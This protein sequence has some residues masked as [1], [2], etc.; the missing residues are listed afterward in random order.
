MSG[1]GWKERII[2]LR[3]PARCLLCGRVVPAGEIFC[4]DCVKEI[5]EKP[6][7]RRIALPGAGAEGFFVYS[8]MSYEGGFR[9]SIH[10][11]KFRGQKGLADPMGR[12]LA[13]S[14]RDKDLS[15]DAVTW[16]PMT[17]KK[18]RER[19]Y[20]QSELLARAAAKELGIPCLP[21]LKKVRENKTQH[22]LSGRQRQL[23]VKNAYRAENGAEGKALLLI[24]DIVTTGATIGECAKMLYAAGANKVTGLCAADAREVRFEGEK[25]L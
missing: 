11:L 13:E 21:L 4:R 23:N 8:S 19:G 18:R 10:R 22:E 15:F 16:V 17:E 6:F 9:K 24:D 12:L 5:P 20:D 2:S 1:V 14:I 25:A 7:F 3:F